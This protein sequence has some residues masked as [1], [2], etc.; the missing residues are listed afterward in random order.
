MNLTRIPIRGKRLF[1]NILSNEWLISRFSIKK[2]ELV[3]YKPFEKTLL[4]PVDVIAALMGEI[5]L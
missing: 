3:Q 1:L 2:S 4:T 5:A